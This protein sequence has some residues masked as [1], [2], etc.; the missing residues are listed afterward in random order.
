MMQTHYERRKYSECYIKYFDISVIPYDI[1]MR[2]P[3]CIYL[4]VGKIDRYGTLSN[5][6]TIKL[7]ALY[8]YGFSNDSEFLRTVLSSIE[9]KSIVL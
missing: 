7:V 8:Y 1:S 4:M 6:A 3:H 5:F 2:V 9:T